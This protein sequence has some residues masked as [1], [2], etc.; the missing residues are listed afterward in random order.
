MRIC[1]LALDT[2]YPE[3]SV[4]IDA[5]ICGLPGIPERNWKA[6]QVI[7]LFDDMAPQLLVEPA[8]LYITDQCCAIFLPRFTREKPAILIHCRGKI[9][10]TQYNILPPHKSKAGYLSTVS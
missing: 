10:V 6:I 4:D 8:S 2:R 5:Q 9:P 1:L 3:H 7:E